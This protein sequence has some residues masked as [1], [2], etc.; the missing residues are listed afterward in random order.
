VT[1]VVLSDSR[2]ADHTWHGH[3]ERAARLHAIER[4]IAA[5]GLYPALHMVDPQ[6]APESALLA[7][8]EPHLLR[9]IRQMA[10]F[11]GGQFDSDTYVTADSWEI[12]ELAA[13]AGIGAV[14]AVVSGQADN[15]FALVRPPGHHA[16]PSR[17]MGFCLINNIAVGARYAI[18]QLGLSRVAIVDFDVHHG[19]GTQD[20][21]YNEPR[22]LFCSTHAAPFYP[23]TGSL[24]E[25]G[26]PSL[27]PGSI[28]NVP[29]P[30]GVGDRGYTQVFHDVITPAL[31][32]FQPELILVSAG[33]DAHW[34]DP[35]G[36]M[37]LTVNGYVGLTRILL[38]LAAELCSGRIV[39]FL[40]GGY[41]LDALA[42]GVVAVLR[43]LVGRPP[44]P[45]PLGAVDEREPDLAVL[46]GR[47][48]REH[49]LLSGR[50]GG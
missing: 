49:P 11:G 38:D 1:T 24:N 47:L 2:F 28:L 48:R 27:A 50:S 30:Y 22:V 32:Q 15:A 45:D 43:L 29:L 7:V 37:L 39:F 18:D 13:G 6:P 40:E 9:A 34:G 20:V 36:P 3:V 17:A 31:Q 8:H 19:N 14:E 26:S 23:G 25:T 16:T 42:A 33:F 10:S 41:N 46:I 21:F 5:A 12:A 4:A 35:L 44:G